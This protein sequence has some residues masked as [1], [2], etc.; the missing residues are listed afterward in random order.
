MVERTATDLSAQ[1]VGAVHR[2]AIEHCTT[3]QPTP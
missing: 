1:A 2:A 3:D